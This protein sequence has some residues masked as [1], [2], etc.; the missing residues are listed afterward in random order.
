MLLHD[1]GHRLR[2]RADPSG[3]GGGAVVLVHVHPRTPQ[4]L[5]YPFSEVDPR[6]RSDR[7][8]VDIRSR[9]LHDEVTNESAHRIGFYVRLVSDTTDILKTPC[10]TR[11]NKTAT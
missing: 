3:H 4:R 7:Y 8:K 6:A 9:P 1:L 2:E 5:P 11:R 10:N